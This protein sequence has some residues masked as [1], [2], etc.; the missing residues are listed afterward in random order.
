MTT[1]DNTSKPA[2]DSEPCGPCG[3]AKQAGDGSGF[4]WADLALGVL[5]VGFG[6]AIIVMGFDLASGGALA[7][8]IGVIPDASGE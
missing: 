1:A 7:K 4:R 8:R 2:T 6:I 5:A 3:E